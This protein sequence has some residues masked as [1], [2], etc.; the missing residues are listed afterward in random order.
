MTTEGLHIPIALPFANCE[1]GAI[2]LVLCFSPKLQGYCLSFSKK[3]KTTP[4]R[5]G[6]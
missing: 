1:P 2:A 5:R 6:S 4:K 3:Q